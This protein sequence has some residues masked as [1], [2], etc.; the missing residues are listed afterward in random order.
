VFDPGLTH[1][2]QEAAASLA[3]REPSFR[4]QRALMDGGSCE[5]TAY[6]LWGVRAGALCL[7]LG[8][9]HNCGPRGAIAPEFVDWDDLEGLIRLLVEAATTW[10]RHEPGAR[11]RARLERIWAAERG[12]LAASA[13]RLRASK[14]RGADDGRDELGRR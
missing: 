10:R 8:N 7:A 2:L 13:R 4:F 12:R 11:M 1:H 3:A 6:N 5:S 9:Y 14:T